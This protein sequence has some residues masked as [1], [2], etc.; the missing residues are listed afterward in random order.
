M[1]MIRRTRNGQ[2]TFAWTRLRSQ[3]IAS[4]L[5]SVVRWSRSMAS[6]NGTR[7]GPARCH[8]IFDVPTA[9]RCSFAPYLGAD[10]KPQTIIDRYFDPDL[11]TAGYIA[12][13]GLQHQAFADIYDASRTR[14]VRDASD[15]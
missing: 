3:C 8:S 6:M 7:R 10:G 1:P 11:F 13:E 4:S 15:V 5:P 9:S 2:S 12:Q 14:Y